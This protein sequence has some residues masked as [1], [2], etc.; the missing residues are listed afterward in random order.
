[1]SEFDIQ[2]AAR[3]LAQEARGEPPEGQTAV[4]WTLRN[5]LA[6]ERWGRSLASV[7]LWRAQFDGWYSPRG[8]PPVQDPNFAYAC[9]LSDDDPVLLQ[10]IQVI[11]DVMSSDQDSTGG[12]THYYAMSMVTPPL[13]VEGATF[14]GQF[15]HQKFYKD[16][17]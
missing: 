9:G 14:C 16:V 11:N 17:K 15:G 10:M 4:A 1:M 13:W 3:T 7:C 5:R 8:N 6:S 12:A 2:V